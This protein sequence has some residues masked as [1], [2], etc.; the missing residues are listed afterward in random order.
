MTLTVEEIELIEDELILDSDHRTTQALR[1]IYDLYLQF[2]RRALE[3]E[4]NLRASDREY[5]RAIRALK[6]ERPNV[7]AIMTAILTGL[8]DE[9]VEVSV[10]AWDAIERRIREL[11]EKEQ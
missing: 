8:N 3:A 10:A 11:I 5:D 7:T 1:K 4:A 9:E 6:E 2:R